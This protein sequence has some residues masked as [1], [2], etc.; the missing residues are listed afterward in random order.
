MKRILLSLTLLM[1]L[2]VLLQAC[3]KDDLKE[4]TISAT[5]KK[6][7][8]Y[9]HN[10]GLMGIEDGFTVSKQPARY[11]TSA[12]SM[13]DVGNVIYTYQPAEDFVG[14]DQVEFT[15]SM[16]NGASVY[17]TRKTTLKLTVTD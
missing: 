6:N 5:V 4:Q 12:L 3:K 2:V 13:D 10:F 16:S 9:Q 1:T 15:L 7:Q 11:V 17:G 8:L 14:R